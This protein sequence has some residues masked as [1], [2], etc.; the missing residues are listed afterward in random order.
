[1]SASALLLD[2]NVW[3][4]YE[5]GNPSPDGQACCELVAWCLSNDV[6]LGIAAHSLKDLF[7]LIERDLKRQNAEAAGDMPKIDDDHVGGAARAAAWAVVEQLVER[8]EV[9]RTR[10]WACSMKMA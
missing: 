4:D 2:T 6:R 10:S 8:V 7:A 5:M 9:A 3:F 1:M